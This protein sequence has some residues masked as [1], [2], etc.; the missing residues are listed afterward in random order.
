MKVDITEDKYL[1]KGVEISEKQPTINSYKRSFK[2]TK[3]N[4][5][6]SNLLLDTKFASVANQT[7]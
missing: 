4:G 2:K 3:K 6:F 1:E 7:F 5:F